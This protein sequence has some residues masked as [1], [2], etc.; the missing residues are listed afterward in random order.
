MGKLWTLGSVT[1]DLGILW[2]SSDLFGFVKDARADCM[3]KP[4]SF[5]LSFLAGAVGVTLQTVCPQEYSV[6]IPQFDVKL[7]AVENKLNAEI[8]F[9]LYI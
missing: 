2:D 1:N 9:G 3:T 8:R 6:L 4:W 7:S 5:R